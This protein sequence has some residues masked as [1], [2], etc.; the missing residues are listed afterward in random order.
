M[1]TNAH[2]APANRPTGQ[3]MMHCWLPCQLLVL[4]ASYDYRLS[5]IHAPA[6]QPCMIPRRAAAAGCCAPLHGCMVRG[7]DP[8]EYYEYRYS[9]TVEAVALPVRMASIPGH[10][11]AYE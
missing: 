2:H 5:I 11:P 9:S 6:A 8:Y 3:C 4:C 10:L 7:G 1:P